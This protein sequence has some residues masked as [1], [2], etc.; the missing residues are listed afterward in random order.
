MKILF[1]CRA[2]IFR[3]QIAAALCQKI[4]EGVHEVRSAGTTVA[5]KAEN[6]KLYEKKD[7]EVEI[8]IDMMNEEGIDMRDKERH[9]L[10]E[11]DVDWADKVI[12]MAEQSTIPEYLL[13]SGKMEYWQVEDSGAASDYDFFVETKDRLKK[14]IEKLLAGFV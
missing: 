11:K 2:N 14:K 13:Q 6:Q 4:C 9:A 8:I 1:V 7:R 3:S 12:C 5:E 10:T